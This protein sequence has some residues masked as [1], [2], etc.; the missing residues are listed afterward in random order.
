MELFFRSDKNDMHAP[1][2]AILGLSQFARNDETEVRDRILAEQQC[3]QQVYDEFASLQEK[4]LLGAGGASKLEQL[5]DGI[6]KLGRMAEDEKEKYNSSEAQAHRSKANTDS[7]AQVT[8]N[9]YS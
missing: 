9:D 8:T 7:R 2:D 1:N 6:E 3:L 5:K 4:G